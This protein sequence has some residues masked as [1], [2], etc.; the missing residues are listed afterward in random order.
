[1][2]LDPLLTDASLLGELGRRLA[3][4]RLA[5][6]LSKAEVAHEAGVARPTVQRIEAGRPVSLPNI[7]S[8]TPEVRPA[9]EPWRWGDEQ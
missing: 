8:R 3:R 4:T 1:M 5:R 6:N 2:G 7:H 9:D